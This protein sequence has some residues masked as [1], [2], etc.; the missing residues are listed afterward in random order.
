MTQLQMEF[1]KQEIPAISGLTYI[2]EYITRAQEASLLEFID[3]QDWI[4]Q[5][6]SLAFH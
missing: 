2:P 3:K 5:L 1:S 4:L 6:Y